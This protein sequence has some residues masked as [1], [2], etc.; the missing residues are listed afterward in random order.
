MEKDFVSPSLS[1]ARPISLSP[2]HG[3]PAPLPL[4]SLRG[5]V[6]GFGPSASTARVRAPRF[7][8]A[9]DRPTPRPRVSARLGPL[10]G[11]VFH[12]ESE[13][14]TTHSESVQPLQSVKLIYQPCSRS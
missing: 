4:S 12:L 6:P 5:P 11:L 8:A 2:P 14:V 3:L 10:V 1:R 7:A 13:P 9:A